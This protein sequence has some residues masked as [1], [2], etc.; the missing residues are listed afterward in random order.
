[1]KIS[2]PKLASAPK[3]AERPQL[4]T[5]KSGS[6]GS[7][8]T[9]PSKPADSFQTQQVKPS[10]TGSTGGTSSAT[11]TSSVAIP[12]TQSTSTYTLPPNLE[13]H[14]AT[15]D[16]VGQRIGNL[17]THVQE[18]AILRESS[19]LSKDFEG[20][21]SPSEVETSV[22]AAAA[23]WGRSTTTDDPHAY[24]A[25]SRV[26]DT[27]VDTAKD[28]SSVKDR[29]I[30]YGRSVTR[31]PSALNPRHILRNAR[32]P[33]QEQQEQQPEETRQL[34]RRMPRWF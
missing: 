5:P 24:A 12:K 31:D 27:A 4:A 14:R 25:A 18:D 21:A 9:A 7:V 15:F 6:T 1:M 30:D 29:V 17:P 33:R 13:P 8:P 11:G 28:V 3:T 19:R 34:F 10:G 32:Q 16:R 22:R 23:Y 20:I 2:H 26:V